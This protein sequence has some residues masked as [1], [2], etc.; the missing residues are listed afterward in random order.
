MGKKSN[1]LIFGSRKCNL[2]RLNVDDEKEK[3]FE[4]KIGLNTK[5]LDRISNLRMRNN[6]LAVQRKGNNFIKIYDVMSNTFVK[7]YE[8]D[9]GKYAVLCVG[10]FNKDMLSNSALK[11]FKIPK[12]KK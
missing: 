12:T 4:S 3:H 2:F 11:G 9:D 6:L 8:I 7:L 1:D 5:D 10:I